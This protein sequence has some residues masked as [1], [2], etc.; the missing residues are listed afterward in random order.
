M[1]I[2]NVLYI[3][4]IF[5]FEYRLGDQNRYT[6]VPPLLVIAGIGYI[7]SSLYRYIVTTS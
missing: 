2:Y 7:D 3:I 1:P 6:N 4:F 5:I